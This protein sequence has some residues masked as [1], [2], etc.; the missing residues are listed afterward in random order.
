MSTFA[1]LVVPLPRSLSVFMSTS[2]SK[3]GFNLVLPMFVPRFCRRDKEVPCGRTSISATVVSLVTDAGPANSALL[4]F[5]PFHHVLL[6]R[7]S[8]LPASVSTERGHATLAGAVL[9]TKLRR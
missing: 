9:P 1:V 3:A 2:Q 5:S 7:H 8:L 6:V 4:I